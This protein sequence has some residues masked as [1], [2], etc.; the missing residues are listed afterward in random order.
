MDIMIDYSNAEK[1]TAY[2][3]DGTITQTIRNPGE[4]SVEITVARDQE[5]ALKELVQM[6]ARRNEYI[7]ALENAIYDMGDA[8]YNETE[9]L[10]GTTKEIYEL[11][12]N[13]KWEKK[14]AAPITEKGGNEKAA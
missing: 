14:V 2:N 6:I 9:D 11:L 7:L 4:T 5:V 1:Y 13:H 3:A 12:Y 10:V 8:H